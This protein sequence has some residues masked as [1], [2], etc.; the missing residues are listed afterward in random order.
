MYEHLVE[1][2]KCDVISIAVF[3][4][5]LELCFEGVRPDWVY[6]G[7]MA[8][9]SPRVWANLRAMMAERPAK[10]PN[11]CFGKVCYDAAPEHR[12]SVVGR[13]DKLGSV[14]SGGVLLW[15][16]PGSGKTHFCLT[17]K[18]V[19]GLAVLDGDEIMKDAGLWRVK[20]RLMRESHDSKRLNQ[21]LRQQVYEP[22]VKLMIAMAVRKRSV[23]MTAVVP[24]Y[25]I[26]AADAAGV[27]VVACCPS[28]QTVRS[29]F[30]GGAH[31][32]VPGQPGLEESLAKNA[33]TLGSMHH[34]GLHV[35]GTISDAL[36]SLP[37]EQSYRE[38][39]RQACL[40]WLEK[41]V[42]GRSEWSDTFYRR[43]RH[44]FP[45]SSE[46]LRQREKFSISLVLK[47]WR[48]CSVPSD[49]ARDLRLIAEKSL[50]MG[51]QFLVNAALCLLL[52]VSC[53][54]MLVGMAGLGVMQSGLAWYIKVAKEV[55]SV[56]RSAGSCWCPM[57]G[58]TGDE[59]YVQVMYVD[60]LAGR[61]SF[62]AL[63]STDEIITRSVHGR[64]QRAY[65]RGGGWSEAEFERQ[66]GVSMDRI[67]A[68]VWAAKQRG[69]KHNVSA[70]IAHF[71]SLGTSG[72]ASEARRVNVEVAGTREQLMSPTKNLWLGMLNE[73]T[74][75]QFLKDN[76]PQIK[77]R[78]IDK[79]ESSKLRLLLP[80]PLRH[81]FIESIALWGVE[82]HVF[83]NN[84]D[85]ALEES[86]VEELLA[87][88]TRLMNLGGRVG[89]KGCSDFK[90]F[91]ILHT[92]P[93]MKRQWLKLAEAV[94]PGGDVNVFRAEWGDMTLAEFS[95]MAARWCCAALD[96]VEARGGKV[97]D[98]W[99][100]LVRGL[101]TGWRSTTFINTTH[102]KHYDYVITSTAREIYGTAGMV[103]TSRV[104]DDTEGD[105][106]SEY[107][108]LC[109]MSVIDQMGLD[110]QAVKQL[111]STERREFLRLMYANGEIKGSLNRAIG[112]ATSSDLQGEA[113]Q[114]G[115]QAVQAAGSI[116]NTWLSRGGD[117]LAIDNFWF[118]VLTYM[119]SVIIYVD[120]S[121]RRV[122]PSHGLISACSMKGGL[123][124][125][126][127]GCVE[128]MP[129]SAITKMRAPTRRQLIQPI[130]R[131]LRGE[132]QDIMVASAAAQFHSRGYKLSGADEVKDDVMSAMLGASLP[133]S[134]LKAVQRSERNCVAEWYKNNRGV[135]TVAVDVPSRIEKIVGQTLD[136]WAISCARQGMPPRGV[137][138]EGS[139]NSA[140]ALAKGTLACVDSVLDRVK[141]VGSGAVSMWRKVRDLG[142]PTVVELTNGVASVIGQSMT[143]AILGG[144]M[145]L[146][147][148]SGGS[149]GSAH[150]ALLDACFSAV[151][152]DQNFNQTLFPGDADHLQN[153]AAAVASAVR[154]QLLAH[155]YWG[156]QQ[157]Y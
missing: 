151:A 134:A 106:V 75:S 85:I 18:P 98:N 156:P 111:V 27:R 122:A 114:G 32:R 28:E 53:R 119:G 88:T 153:S 86:A 21:L 136:I 66:V 55:H 144:T 77:G 93:R 42:S 62:P 47:M 31:V 43:L 116:M 99:V 24:D 70:S 95:A 121:A 17:A 109:Y 12:S 79:F 20:D 87:Y 35:H 23:V 57:L 83:K 154:T 128:Q 133:P 96:S 129:T 92:F 105:F 120:G 36:A 51:G 30:A 130:A 25:A 76:E 127:R 148:P 50:G 41:F 135:Q 149:V 22:G 9:R 46:A 115:P 146:T 48:V 126:Q 1:C 2:V 97:G 118:P 110:A 37:D 100:E 39:W 40:T 8:V 90:D 143:E 44:M 150:R 89:T 3:S 49:M 140:L 58:L 102:N 60:I 69:D 155:E 82:S 54:R 103:R 19:S 108:C 59:D 141:S 138:I 5:W 137:A 132:V 145:L 104:G 78:G 113:F 117:P 124:V 52:N 13:D 45:S 10:L 34:F 65:T 64:P 125:V 101:W 152:E 4:D 139:I 142:G 131:Q 63:S 68:G 29:N 74:V 73:R 81:W 71:T 15:A 112:N 67:L 94:W 72:A 14:G 26:D 7:L 157:Q 80:G 6:S 107:D 91:N 84:P 56:T 147:I 11:E 38:E 123:G 16:P 61:F 33:K